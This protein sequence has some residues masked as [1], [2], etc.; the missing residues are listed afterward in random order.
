MGIGSAS[1]M[2]YMVRGEIRNEKPA[3]IGKKRHDRSAF[4][5]DVQVELSW[6]RLVPLQIPIQVRNKK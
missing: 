4:V 2:L 5:L 1:R 6:V 3:S